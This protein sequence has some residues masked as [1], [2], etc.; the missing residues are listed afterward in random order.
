M[1]N[2]NLMFKSVP[3]CSLQVFTTLIFVLKICAHQDKIRN[4]ICPCQSQISIS[5]VIVPASYSSFSHI[6]NSHAHRIDISLFGVVLYLSTTEMYFTIEASL[7]EVDT[8]AAC[9]VVDDK[10]LVEICKQK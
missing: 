10:Q 5:N 1:V 9:I 7:I 4:S 6:S 8:K 3:N 2:L